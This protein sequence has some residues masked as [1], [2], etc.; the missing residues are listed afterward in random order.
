MSFRLDLLPK[1]KYVVPG[2]AACAGCG[3]M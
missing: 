3:M 1:K 2:N